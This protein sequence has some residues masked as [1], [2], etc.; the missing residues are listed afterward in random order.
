MTEN[1]KVALEQ[2]GETKLLPASNYLSAGIHIGMKQRVKAMDR[3]IY[4]VRS[5]KLAVFNVQLI[6]EQIQN[7]ANLLSQYNPEDILVVSRKKNGHK[8]VVK[9]AE[10]IGGAKVIYGRFYPGT[11][12]NPNYE[13]YIE[14]KIVI[15]TDPFLDKQI[16]DEAFNS[17]VPIVGLCDT[18]NN[19]KNLDII[20]SMNNKGKK[21]IALV[22]WLLAREILKNKG[23]IKG[24]AEF[25]FTLD[26]FEMPEF[27]ERDTA[28]KK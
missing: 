2:T 6:D 16:V 20:I 21:A 25:K 14:P 18:F 8:P 11:L 28:D 9:F 26:D 23:E 19:P 7:V 13:K 15:V 5:D 24:D 27:E 3:Y 10:A 1:A 17:N 12:T 22:Y 4:K